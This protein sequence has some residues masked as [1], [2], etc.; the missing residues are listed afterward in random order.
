LPATEVGGDA[1]GWV[2]QPNG[3]LAWFILDVA[4]KGLPAA[5]AAVSLHTAI[6]MGL[7]TGLSP[8]EVI[9]TVNAEFYDAYTRTNL[10]ATAAAISL[11][12]HTGV[13]ELANAGHPPLLIRTQRE[14]QRMEASVPPIGVLPHI[15]PE[16]QQITLQPNDLILCYSDGFT[17][18]QVG[19]KLWG[20]SG[21]LETI[22]YGA[23]DV[24]A[25]TKH[26]VE[27]SRR[28]G[29]VNDDQTLVTARY[30][31]ATGTDLL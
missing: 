30:I 31:G 28:V 16:T 24:N 21:L 2:E 26:I 20:E 7:R 27:I 22:P 1:W 9:R 10:M 5:L 6:R 23:R 12:L 4:G 15:V 29:I 25:L 14:W 13:L 17:E 11:D 19:T 3:N 8:T 18:I